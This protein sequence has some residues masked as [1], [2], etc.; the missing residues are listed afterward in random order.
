M[1]GISEDE[2]KASFSIPTSSNTEHYFVDIDPQDPEAEDVG[3]FDREESGPPQSITQFLTLP[4][5]AARASNRTRDPIVDFTKSV[6]LTADTCL[7]TVEQL[8]EQRDYAARE[9]ERKRIEREEQKKRKAQERDQKAIQKEQRLLERE[10]KATERAEKKAR[11]AIERAEA[12]RLKVERAAERGT[13]RR[14]RNPRSTEHPGA[15]TDIPLTAPVAQNPAAYQPH[16]LQTKA[17][18]S[19]GDREQVWRQGYPLG[20]SGAAFPPFNL[21]APAAQQQQL[22]HNIAMMSASQQFTFPHFQANVVASP[23]LPF[24]TPPPAISHQ[25]PSMP[26]PQSAKSL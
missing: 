17:P 11:L 8:Q 25:S 9:N 23:N 14:P 1:G 7:A 22:M 10:H 16:G 5:I 4:T 24:M 18:Q 15:E 21:F 3:G 26:L 12:Q 2:L 6:M 13:G 19:E 20:N